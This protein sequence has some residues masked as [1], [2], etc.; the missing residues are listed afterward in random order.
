MASKVRLPAN[1][2]KNTKEFQAN[3]N[4][5]AGRQY[6]NFKNV[7]RS[8]FVIDPKTLA[9]RL[10]VR[11][12]FEEVLEGTN[13]RLVR[14]FVWLKRISERWFTHLF[15]LLALILYAC[16]GGAIFSTIEG[17]HEAMQ[18]VKMMFPFL[19]GD[20]EKISN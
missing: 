12:N 17:N 18:N 3:L 14:L 20:L 1:F 10:L 2:T 7:P 5:F 11:P 6:R 13:S 16:L 19:R 8:M 15:L 9:T 4:R